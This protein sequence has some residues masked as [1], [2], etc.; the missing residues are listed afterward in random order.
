MQVGFNP[1]NVD[2]CVCVHKDLAVRASLV[3]EE[4]GQCAWP[5]LR[6]QE[7]LPYPKLSIWRISTCSA[8]DENGEPQYLGD[9]SFVATSSFSKPDFPV[10]ALKNPFYKNPGSTRKPQIKVS[11]PDSTVKELVRKNQ[12][13]E[14]T[15]R[16]LKCDME[17]ERNMLV[18]QVK[19]LE[20][21]SKQTTNELESLRQELYLLRSSKAMVEAS[22]AEETQKNERLTSQ[23]D[24]LVRQP[25][26]ASSTQEIRALRNTVDHL[27]VQL[28]L[29]VS[30]LSQLQK[31]Y[32]DLR[33][34]QVASKP[35]IHDIP[36][37]PSKIDRKPAMHSQKRNLFVKNI[38]KSIT[39]ERF[40]EIFEELYLGN[41]TS[42]VI[43]KDD[44]GESK[45]F[46]F[47]CYETEE[48]AYAAIQ[49]MHG[50]KIDGHSKALYVAFAQ[51]KEQRKV[52]LQRRFTQ[53][54]QW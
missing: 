14:A 15:I 9:H 10:Y 49:V 30:E 45:G 53:E 3:Q 37:S 40:E 31:Q 35:V 32:D 43:M 24:N 54:Q 39:D 22:L 25:R 26:D 47:V 18:Q 8:V 6:R 41:I 2:Q 44:W 33:S 48:A 27:N 21:H 34:T 11:A 23:M 46:G 19:S 17:S 4:D 38:P 50:Q 42:A 29:S 52:E 13:L 51:P 20:L 36:V 16:S 1:P 5:D 28:G 12:Q 7:C